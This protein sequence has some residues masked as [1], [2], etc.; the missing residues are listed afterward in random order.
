MNSFRII[1]FAKHKGF[2]L[3][4]LQLFFPLRLRVAEKQGKAPSLVTSRMENL[5]L[6]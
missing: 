1:Y 6:V 3:P 2:L 5:C 4:V